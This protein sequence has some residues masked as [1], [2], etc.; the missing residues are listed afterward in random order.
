MATP[1]RRQAL[2]AALLSDGWREMPDKRT[3]SHRV[4]ENLNI[5]V[6][7]VRMRMRIWIGRN[8]SMR[9]GSVKSRTLV[10]S[11]NPGD[12]VESAENMVKRGRGMLG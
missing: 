9:C 2:V 11:Y 10:Q 1:T 12:W 5:T 6:E 4:M 7:N 3:H 8:G